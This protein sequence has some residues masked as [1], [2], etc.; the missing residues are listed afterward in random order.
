MP[1]RPERKAGNTRL[2][3]EEE[4]RIEQRALE[5]TREQ[6]EDGYMAGTIDHEID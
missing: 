3:K 5:E 2:S 4:L 1:E 6:I